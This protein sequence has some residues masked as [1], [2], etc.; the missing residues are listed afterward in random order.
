M[1]NP[2]IVLLL[3]FTIIA[4]SCSETPEEPLYDGPVTEVPFTA[5]KITDQ[6]WARRIRINKENTI[7]HTL[8]KCEASGR[9]KNFQ[10]AGGL[11]EGDRYVTDF[12]FDDTDIYKIIEGASY[13]LQ[14][15]YDPE[16]VSYMDSLLVFM[17]AAQEEDGYLYPAGTIAEKFPEHRHDWLGD[18]RWEKEEDLSHELYNLGH[19][20]EGSIAHFQATGDSVMLKIAMRFADLA[21]RDFG[22]GKIE[23][24]PGHQVTEMALTKLYKQT[25]K[26]Q[27]LDLAKFFLDV[28]GQSDI[29]KKSK[30]GQ[31]PAYSQAHALV[32]NQDE[33]V[34][35]AVRATY[36]YSGMADIASLM[37]DEAYRTA[38]DNIWESAVHQK[39][40]VT[41]GIGATG[42]GEA[43]GDAYDLPNMSAYSETCASIGNVYWN[44]RMFLLHEDAKY[45]D[46][47]ERTMYNSL[48]AGIG[49]DGKSFFY[50]NPL[51]SVGQHKRSPWFNCAC[52]PSNVTRFIPSVPKYVYAKRG[53]QAI[54]VNLFLSNDATIQLGNT[55]VNIVQDSEMPFGG[56]T[57]FTI[58][59]ESKKTFDL[60]IRVP[61]WATGDP[62]PGDL[63]E[64][65]SPEVAPLEVTL[66][67][68]AI[69]YEQ[70]KGYIKIARKWSQGDEVTVDF[71]METK[72]IKAHEKVAADQG[73]VAVQRGPLVYCAEW[74]DNPEGVHNLLIDADATFEATYQDDLLQ[75]IMT[76]TTEAKA[77]AY[78]DAGELESQSVTATLIPYYSWV[79]RG[80]G[81]MTVWLATETEAVTPV[82]PP[83]I[84]SQSK[85]ELSH[86]NGATSSINDQVL[87]QN[88]NDHEVPYYHWWPKKNTVEW[89]TYEFQEAKELSESAVYW[90]DDGPWGGCRVPASW[91]VYYQNEQGEWLPVQSTMA[92]TMDK[93]REN[94]VTFKP[95]TT[96]AM[97]LEVKLPEN[98]AAGLYEWSVR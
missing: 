78:G 44:Y 20:I 26:R 2:R 72:T 62:I 1:I 79:N 16:L 3:F 39:T 71:P 5:V 97:K 41:G 17:E 24:A 74:V 60:L 14:S 21:A 6:F 87:P 37:N 54:Y 90:F 95:V 52:C 40:Y 76:L 83:S 66:N 85:M 75:G 58:S 18:E 12:P 11:M 94:L 38:T 13:S 32:V 55:K 47:L 86:P 25:G 59:P 50:P 28:K 84:A 63:Y 31:G 4:F 88:S 34:G 70:D 51:K 80:A 81:D 9:V 23:K 15:D 67:G 61:G 29:V 91:K 92:Y 42:H 48:L 7:P 98:H 30:R 53:N 69:A 45:Y 36:M 65:V 43:F 10:I 68:R 77:Y 8:G 73:R 96:K 35:H 89:I 22:W 27:Y 19:L 57:Q 56:K 82:R 49:L 93:D 64:F 33:A 46:V